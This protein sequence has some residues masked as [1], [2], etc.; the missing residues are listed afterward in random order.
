MWTV[1]FFPFLC[2]YVNEFSKCGAYHHHVEDI[3]VDLLQA[4]ETCVTWRICKS[5]IM[6]DLHVSFS[7]ARWLIHSLPYNLLYYHGMCTPFKSVCDNL[8]D[9]PTPIKVKPLVGLRDW[10]FY[11]NTTY[12]KMKW[13][14]WSYV[15][16]G[17]KVYTMYAWYQVI[18]TSTMTF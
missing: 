15:T 11:T 14:R 7:D 6:V 17:D 12:Y 1:I 18:C 3:Y 10:P 2:G 13:K 9:S 8:Y 16:T 4:Y 5:I